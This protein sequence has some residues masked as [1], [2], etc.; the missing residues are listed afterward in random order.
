MLAET[1]LSPRYGCLFIGVL[2]GAVVLD[3]HGLTVLVARGGAFKIS[4]EGDQLGPFGLQL[5]VSCGE[6]FI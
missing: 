5:C 2:V 1:L 3:V 4:C 6:G